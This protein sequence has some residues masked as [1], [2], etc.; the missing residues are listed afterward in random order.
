MSGLTRRSFIGT[1]TDL[2]F[3]E[4]FGKVDR[5]QDLS[6]SGVAGSYSAGSGHGAPEHRQGNVRCDSQKRRRNHAA[7]IG[8]IYAK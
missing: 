1:D 7:V 2:V 5:F 3:L 8:G 6:F 4:M